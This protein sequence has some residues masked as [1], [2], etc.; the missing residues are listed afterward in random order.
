MLQY[1][2]IKK[3]ETKLTNWHTVIVENDEGN[4]GDVWTH[5]FCKPWK[6]DPQMDK[7]VQMLRDAR[8]R[9]ASQMS[10]NDFCLC[11]SGM[12]V[13]DCRDKGLC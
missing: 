9:K 2:F 6:H 1:S 12:K 10:R 5:T 13:K 7:V 4:V 11:G 8:A 3:Y